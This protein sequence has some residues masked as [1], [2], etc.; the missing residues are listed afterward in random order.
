MH[1]GSKFNAN[2]FGIKSFG[3][4][5]LFYPFWLSFDFCFAFGYYYLCKGRYTAISMMKSSYFSYQVA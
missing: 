1:G 4:T 2:L 3:A 5:F